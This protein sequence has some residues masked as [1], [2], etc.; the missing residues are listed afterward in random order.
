MKLTSLT[1]YSLKSVILS[2]G[3]SGLQPFYRVNEKNETLKVVVRTPQ[4]PKVCVVKSIP[5][6]LEVEGKLTPGEVSDLR[7]MF[8]LDDDL[9]EFYKVSNQ[10]KRSWI[11][12]NKMGRMLRSQDPFEDLIKLI[13][14]TNCSWGFTKKMVE[15][16]C[17][18]LGEK[19]QDGLLL[20]P[21]ALQVSKKT[22][23]F[24][25]DKIRA[26]YRSPHLP[27]IAN[28]VLKREIDLEV[29]RD[30]LETPELR[31]KIL[32]IPGAG[33]YVA[34]NLLRLMGRYDYLGVDSWVRKT[35]TQ[36]WKKKKPVTDKD[37]E[38]VYQKFGTYKGLG[39]WCDVTKD[40][41]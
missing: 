7:Y 8:R 31:K 32:S 38:K 16:M 35:L 5:N 33:P 13:L 12:K 25:R 30:T 18:F 22:E 34:D 39:M 41:F 4:G 40:W 28:M 27:K 37:I 20:F 11:E 10:E 19:T 1:P 26:G 15:N 2:H 21:T 14:T 23:A 36:Q 6:G 3:W 29:W 24:Y 17:V 9:S